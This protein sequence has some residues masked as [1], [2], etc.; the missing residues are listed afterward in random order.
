MVMVHQPG[1]FNK[2]RHPDWLKVK[3]PSGKSYNL[4]NSLVKSAS[5]NTVC[6]EAKCPNIGECWSR[7]VATF[8]ILG[9]TC[10]RACKYCNVKTGWPNGKVDLNEPKKV[11]DI[12][13][14]LDLK[15][16]VITS[17]D[18][19][20]LKDQGSNI[21]AETIRLIHSNAK[22]MVEVLTPD[23]TDDALKTVLS[24][25][26]EVF[27]HNMEA[28]R[29][30]FNF[31]RS[32]GDY[33]KSLRILKEAKLINKNQKTKS[34]ISIGFGETKEE[35]IETMEDIKKQNVDFLSIGQYL[36][37]T[38]KHIKLEKYYTP[39]EFK[40]FEKIGYDLGFRWVKAGPLVRSS[41][42]AEE[43]ILNNN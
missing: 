31:V 34:A 30:I 40:E 18:R 9:D 5:T 43:A 20:D 16:V 39:E 6:K 38:P 42:R 17:V 27:S 4:I 37:P 1:D 8:M 15:Y 32:K 7:G 19:D 25:K 11:A 33:V 3:L 22:A 35:I 13:K 14:K 26:P 24:A 10:T 2:K 28:V 29:R 36:Q 12:V 21:F 23:Y 41:Y